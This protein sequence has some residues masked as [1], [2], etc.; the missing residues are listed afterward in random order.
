M[1]VNEQ[2]SGIPP[3]R[4]TVALV[5][6]VIAAL[7]VLVLTTLSPNYFTFASGALL[8]VAALMLHRRGSSVRLWGTVIFA[9]GMLPLLFAAMV[10]LTN[11]GSSTQPPLLSVLTLLALVGTPWILAMVG[12][13][14][15]MIWRPAVPPRK[16]PYL[17]TGLVIIGLVIGIGVPVTAYGFIFC[18]GDSC[19]T[20]FTTSAQISAQVTSCTGA[21]GSAPPD[22]VVTLWNSG[23]ASASVMGCNLRLNGVTVV[24][25]LSGGGPLV[26]AGGQISVTCTSAAG[27]SPPVGSQAV[28]SFMMSNGASVPFSGVWS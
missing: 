2:P 7:G 13:L 10:A 28:G 20:G 16:R 1:L 11:S 26:P 23:T 22:C 9:M 18:L 12:G 24:G 21:S 19:G 3:Q 5:L 27:A 25:T 17:T 8:L 15:A 6:S 14:A 4:P